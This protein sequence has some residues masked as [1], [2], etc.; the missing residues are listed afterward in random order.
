LQVAFA[1][2]ADAIQEHKAELNADSCGS[3]ATLAAILPSNIGA[4]FWLGDS[5]AGLLARDPRT[6]KVT[7]DILTTDHD[8]KNVTELRRLEEDYPGAIRTRPD[9]KTLR[10][11]DEGL[12]VTRGFGAL[13]TEGFSAEPDRVFIDLNKY[14][15]KEVW[16]CL[17]CDGILKA[18]R[19]RI[20]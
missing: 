12:A 15:R 17:F 16:L 13:A 6:G 20:L 4:I 5:P 11:G 7:L 19:A 10:L 8:L 14:S 2:T 3:T 9:S 18:F 1:D